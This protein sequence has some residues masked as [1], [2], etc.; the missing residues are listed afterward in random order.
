[1]FRLRIL[2]EEPHTQKTAEAVIG[3]GVDNGT[4]E[5]Q[6]QMDLDEAKE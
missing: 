5:Q 2:R 1:M 4:R 6:S 3:L